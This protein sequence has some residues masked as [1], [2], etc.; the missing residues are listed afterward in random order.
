MTSY[1]RS[2]ALSLLGLVIATR[3][4]VAFAQGSSI[5]KDEC[6][7]ECATSTV[8]S[9]ASALTISEFRLGIG[10]VIH[11]SV[12]KEPELTE[13]AVVLPDGRISMP[14]AGQVPIAGKSTVTAQSLI[15]TLLL[16]YMTDPQVTVSIVE[17]HSRQVYITGQVQHPGAYPLLGNFN[18]LQLIASAGGL[19]PYA[20][21]R[22]IVILDA[23]NRQVARF[24]YSSAVKGNPKQSMM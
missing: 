15:R 21:K 1:K 23:E 17:I 12:W 24:D 22:G 20:R 16:K 9:E 14:L 13:T 10:D 11:I 4:P 3:A 2:A 7:G 18:V 6:P 5:N 19:T 8:V